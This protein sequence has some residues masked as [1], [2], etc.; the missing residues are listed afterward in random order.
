ME[1]DAALIPKVGA[2]PTVGVS[3]APGSD[4]LKYR[5]WPWA[6]PG[7][8]AAFLRLP[9]KRVGSGGQAESD[10]AARRS[11]SS[12]SADGSAEPAAPGIF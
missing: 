3:V 11:R 8:S 4:F 10:W 2:E 1:P 9:P 7:A 12:E 6:L 5:Q